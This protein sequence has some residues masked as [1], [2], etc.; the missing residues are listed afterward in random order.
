MSTSS[1]DPAALQT[2]VTQAEQALRDLSTKV[3]HVQQVAAAF[4]SGGA[5]QLDDGGASAALT[6]YL[7]NAQELDRAV[8]V[9]RQAFLHADGGPGTR[10]LSDA[11]IAAHLRAAG[12]GIPSGPPVSVADPAI[13]GQPVDSGV[14]DDPVN[15]ANG[16][17]VEVE[18]DLD[19]PGRAIAVAWIRTYGSRRHDVAGALGRGWACWADSRLEPVLDSLHWHLPD[20]AVRVLP[21]P[22]GDDPLELADGSGTV[23]ATADGTTIRLWRTRERWD[24]DLAGRPVR[25]ASGPAEAVLTW[26]DG[27][28]VRLTHPR[29]GRWVELVWNGERL[30]TVTSSDGRSVQYRYDDAGDLVAVGRA[31]G[32][33]AYEVENG[34]ITSVTDADGVVEV[35]NTYDAEGRVT[36]QRSSDGRTTRYAYRP[37]LHTVVSGAD[38]D[39]LNAYSHD[40]AGRLLAVTDDAGGTLQRTFDA[41]GRLLSVIDRGGSQTRYEYDD[42]GD[43]VR[44]VDGLGAE[45]VLV[46]DAA[47]RPTAVTDRTGRTTRFGYAGSGRVPTSISDAAGTTTVEVDERDDLPVRVVD[48]DGVAFTLAWDDDGQLTSLRSDA[49]EVRW[50]YDPAGRLVGV[51]G[52]LEESARFDLDEAGRVVVAR[53]GRGAA[54]RF[55]YT[56]AGRTSWV[57]DPLGNRTTGSYD[58][59]GRLTELVDPLGSVVGMS[60]DDRGQTVGLTAPDGREVG[61]SYDGNGRLVS[62]TAPDGAETSRAY[63]ADGLLTSLTTPAGRTVH[64]RYDA[65]ERLSEVAAVELTASVQRDAE[66]RI[67]AVADALGALT[68]HSYDPAG[69]LVE[70]VAPSGARTT[71]AWTPGGRLAAVTGPTGDRTEL[72]YDTAGRLVRVQR[73]DGSVEELVHDAA[74]RLVTQ[75]GT[76]TTTAT[77]AYDAAG[78]VTGYDDGLLQ[79]QVERDLRGYPV[80]VTSGRAV[81]TFAYDARG[82][83]T[84]LRASGLGT[85]RFSYD[86]CG[87]LV[88]VVDPLGGQTSYAYD[89]TGRPLSVTDPLGRRRTLERD[90]DGLVTVERLADGSGRRWSYDAAGR[91]VAVG[92]ADSDA[93]ADTWTLDR[94]GRVVTASGDGGTADV[95][96]DVDGRLVSLRTAAGTL[97]WTRDAAGDVVERTVETVDGTQPLDLPEERPTALAVERDDAGQIT[98][99][100]GPEGPVRLHWDEGGRL[101]AEE[102]SH[103]RRSFGYDAAGQLQWSED[104]TGTT[105]YRY[106]EAGRRVEERR[107]DGTVVGYA[108]DARGRLAAVSRVDTDGT[109]ARCAIRY[110]ALGGVASVGGVPVVCDPTVPGSPVVLLGDQPVARVGDASLIVTPSG[111]RALTT[112]VDPWFRGA[113]D[114]VVLLGQRV[115]D[116]RTRAFLSVD[117]LSPVP[118]RPGAANPYAYCYNDPISWRDPVG[119]RPL[120]ED[121]LKAY[122]QSQERGAFGNAWENVKHDPW[123]TL[124]MVGVVAVGVGLEFVPGGQVIGTGILIGAATSGAFGL[125]TGHFDPRQVALGGIIGGVAGGLGPL[126]GALGAGAGRVAVAGAGAA[127]GSGFGLA[128][129]VATS[130]I[131]GEPI[132]GRGLLGAG[133]GGALAGG[134][135]ALAGGAGGTVARTVFGQTARSGAAEV[136]TMA[137][138][139]GAGAAG[140]V[141]NDLVSG[142]PVTPLDVAVGGVGGAAIGRL[143][144]GVTDAYAPGRGM[145]TLRQ[146]DSFAPQS[147]PAALNPFHGPNS[148]SVVVANATGGAGGASVDIVRASAEHHDKKG[149]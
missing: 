82:A 46:W 36:S 39:G 100:T 29:S 4:R 101:L 40:V 99:F 20:G 79:V 128:S 14:A 24:F 95:E 96:W 84:E 15:T 6:S 110:D 63:D 10:T 5:L 32:D 148:A 122:R 45:L 113:G 41:G 147:V 119:L 13:L 127:I 72:S 33:R 11:A 7:T 146:M 94:A 27:R 50:S 88:E 108:W 143:A 131:K 19:Q 68:T 35:V 30:G 140:A 38:G 3:G 105:S 97:R 85:T 73:P 37:G 64:A 53:D 51:D 16:N 74:G 23:T 138:N 21:A 93:A 18:T 92:A 76:G 71:F 107:P 70:T 135:G 17:F 1:A 136:T 102:T 145:T 31:T 124:A 81:T 114:G 65:A 61:F 118:G 28:L 52:S 58:A 133:A 42:R 142:R 8:A 130:L 80:S 115:L 2:Y 22:A 117:P 56:P 132:T 129:Y 78:A 77:Y 139:A 54:T 44:V 106:D 103:G 121:E 55:G 149:P 60:Y 57:L 91:V 83:V 43:L 104:S 109:A 87:R 86:G 66:G 123:G 34:L 120:T 134:I 47:H 137:I 90:A 126:A 98:A 125:A 141:T 75:S 48:A 112:E 25:V 116:P 9:V 89:P 12:A 144:D 111:A 49:G 67:V 26:A 69:R 59:A 62:A